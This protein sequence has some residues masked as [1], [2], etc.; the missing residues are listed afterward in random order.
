MIC[1]IFRYLW[2]I[3]PRII[4]FKL[5]FKLYNCSKS[6]C[7]AMELHKQLS[8]PSASGG[9]PVS[10]LSW[11]KCYWHQLYACLASSCPVF[12]LQGW[13]HGSCSLHG[14]AAGS[15]VQGGS[16]DHQTIHVV[17]GAPGA[18]PEAA[19]TLRHLAS[20]SKYS[21]MKYAWR[22]P[23]NTHAVTRCQRCLPS[24]HRWL[25]AWD[26]DLPHHSW[27][28][29]CNIWQISPETKLP[30]YLRCTKWEAYCLQVSSKESFPILQ[31]Q[32]ILLGCTYGPCR[33]LTTRLSGRTSVVQDQHQTHWSTITLK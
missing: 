9:S 33:R 5:Y 17:Q 12:M 30:P 21:T 29:A 3:P 31:L 18:W 28:V 10:F 6:S 20:G 14:R 23:H 11:W 16:Q 15:E 13:S 32:G 8:W 25:H 1:I 27:G 4:H 24:H 2:S 7:L 22:V 26:D 19:L